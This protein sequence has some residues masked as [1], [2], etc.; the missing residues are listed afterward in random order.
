MNN[1]QSNPPSDST[2][3]KLNFQ[4]AQNGMS[5]EVSFS[6]SSDDTGV[7]DKY[8][9]TVAVTLGDGGIAEPMSQLVVYGK[10]ATINITANQDMAVDT[11]SDG[12]NEYINNG[13]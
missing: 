13:D 3:T 8:K 9:F 5:I 12:D 1:G 2:W 7:P 4:S 10:S 6:E 11:I